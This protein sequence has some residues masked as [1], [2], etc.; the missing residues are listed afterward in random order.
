MAGINELSSHV[1]VA[2]AMPPQTLSTTTATEV[3]AMQYT[4]IAGWQGAMVILSIGEGVTSDATFTFNVAHS[5]DISTDL[6]AAGMLSSDTFDMPVTLLDSEVSVTVGR[7]YVGDINFKTQ[8]WFDGYIQPV[9]S[10]V[11]PTGETIISSAVFVLYGPTGSS[12]ERS[13]SQTL[14]TAF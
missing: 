11:M 12:A 8:G 9:I 4:N 7:V 6:E 13:Q 14:V 5:S 2:G 10:E 1:Y 3:T